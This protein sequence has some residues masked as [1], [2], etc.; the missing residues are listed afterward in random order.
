MWCS[1]VFTSPRFLSA[2]RLIETLPCVMS[3]WRALDAFAVV[4]NLTDS[5]DPNSG[6]TSPTGAALPIYRP[7]IGRTWSPGL[8]WSWIR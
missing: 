5:R 4:D 6:L 3:S 1:S 7:E 2:R 8:R